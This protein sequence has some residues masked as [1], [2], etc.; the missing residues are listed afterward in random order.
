M[1]EEKKI[2]Q[3]KGNIW[4]K[5]LTLLCLRSVWQE[6]TLL[7]LSVVEL[8]LTSKCLKE[9]PNKVRQTHRS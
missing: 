8:H 3:I 7:S 4:S 9:D 6:T 1:V 5:K 2:T